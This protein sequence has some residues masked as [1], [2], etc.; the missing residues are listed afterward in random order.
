M[1]RRGVGRFSALRFLDLDRQA[2]YAE[3]ARLYGCFNSGSDDNQ[4]AYSRGPDLV[5]FGDSEAFS[6][7]RCISKE[8]LPKYCSELEF[9]WNHRVG[10]EHGWLECPLEVIALREGRRRQGISYPGTIARIMSDGTSIGLARKPY[11]WRLLSILVVAILV[12]TILVTPYALALQADTLKNLKLPLPLPVL[13]PIQWLGNTVFCGL[14]GGLGLAVAGR[15]GLGLPFLEGCLAGK[16]DWAYLRRFAWRGVLAG[17]LLTVSVLLLQKW[18]FDPHLSA[19]FK[20]KLPHSNVPLWRWSLASFYGGV[21]E[22]IMLRLFLLSVLAW[23]GRFVNRTSAGRP[24]WGALW[25]ANVVAAV[26]FG[27]GHLPAFLTIGVPIDAVVI[28]RAIVLNGLGGLVF[29]WFFWTFGLEAAMVSH[30]SADLMLHVIWPL[31]AG[32]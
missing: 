8:H 7:G 16:P 24:G 23:L 2:P 11:N 28:T 14:L 21:T 25:F 19:Q 26:L 13:I 31:L 18:V 9:R 6:D 30:F 1:R 4:W 20:Q 10:W 12:S 17:A 32:H 5:C 15:I 27:L 3:K 22:E 29:G